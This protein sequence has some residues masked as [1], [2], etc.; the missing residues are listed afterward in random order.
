MS[1]STKA[2]HVWEYAYESLR[3]HVPAVRSIVVLIIAA[4]FHHL[5]SRVSPALALW[6]D[7]IRFEIV[8]T[9]AGAID[10][11]PLADARISISS[12][13]S[14]VGFWNMSRLQKQEYTYWIMCGLPAFARQKRFA[15]ALPMLVLD[16]VA[17]I[18]A[19]QV[20]AG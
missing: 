8:K 12:I 16:V 5:A 19:D 18:G 15:S 11:S 4:Q 14:I 3:V 6:I 1:V 7:F 20:I 13:V 9:E 10:G 17:K 2:N